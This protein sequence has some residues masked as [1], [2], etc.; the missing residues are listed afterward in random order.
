MTMPALADLTGTYVLDPAHTRI[1]FVARH[2]MITKVRGSFAEFEGT[3]KLDGSDPA[4]SG[5]WSPSSPTASTPATSSETDT[6]GPTT[7]S[8]PRTTRG[9]PSPRPGSSSW[10]AATSG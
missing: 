10:T 1:G 4:K 2:A 9:S 3:L 7:F 8:M 5:V 6:C